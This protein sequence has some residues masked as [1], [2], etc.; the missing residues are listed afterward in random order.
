MLS[1]ITAS[2][3]LEGTWTIPSVASPS[4]AVASVNAVTVF[5]SRHVP[6]QKQQ[7]QHEQQVV[8]TRQDVLDAKGEIGPATLQA[9]RRVG[10]T[11]PGCCGV[12]R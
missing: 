11:D 2:T 10:M 6:C 3:G 9:L 1:A 12:R 8:E 7:G 4:D 5:T